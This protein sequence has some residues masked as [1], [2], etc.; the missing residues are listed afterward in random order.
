MLIGWPRALVAVKVLCL[1]LGRSITRD[2]ATHRPVAVLLVLN[3]APRPWPPDP[4]TPA[5]TSSFSPLHATMAM[6]TPAPT[7]PGR[8]LRR[9]LRRRHCRLRPAAVSPVPTI[10]PD[11]LPRPP[12]YSC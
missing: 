11:C 12:F 6:A 1:S 10:E 7:S 4:T 9:P 2:P 8:L 5:A 3:G